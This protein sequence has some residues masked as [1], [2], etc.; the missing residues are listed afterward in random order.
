MDYFG[1]RYYDSRIGRWGSV[2][3]LAEKFPGVSPYNYCLN[4]PVKLFDPNGKE[5]VK[6]SIGSAQGAESVIRKI[7]L[8]SEQSLLS[9]RDVNANPFITTAEGKDNR[10]I[11]TNS[12]EFIDMLHFTK[13]AAE[14]YARSPQGDGLVDKYFEQIAVLAVQAGGLFTEIKQGLSSDANIRH[15]FMSREDLRSNA[16]GSLFAM[17]Y[18]PNESLHKQVLKFLSQMGAITKK[19]Y[20]KMYKEAYDEMPED[21]AEARE[22]YKGN[23]ND[24]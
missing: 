13:A 7:P 10:Y 16:L 23:E 9:F 11:P 15:S 20:I 22:R 14:T 24:K 19:Q 1:A 6:K 5:P 17:T 21:E 8:N 3:P 2:D 4:D 18:K 12:G